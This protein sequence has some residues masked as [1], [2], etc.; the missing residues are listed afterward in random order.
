MKIQEI[1]SQDCIWVEK[2]ALPKRKMLE[3]ISHL[4]AEKTGLPEA[5]ILDALVER[6]RL[7]T[8]GIGRGLCLIP[9]FPI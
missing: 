9:R 4:A 5:V 7:G 1:L 8:T 2:N 6:E 3:K